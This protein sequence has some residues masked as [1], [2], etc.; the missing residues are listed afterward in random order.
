MSENED[1]EPAPV[2]QDEPEV[3]ESE[4]PKAKEPEK[5]AAKPDKKDDKDDEDSV[6]PTGNRPHWARGL[7]VFA[8]GAAIP[9][10][11]MC[12]DQHWPFSVP[13]GL[14]GC[15][16]AAWGLFDAFGTFDDSTVTRR[17]DIAKLRPAA[18][19]LGTAIAAWF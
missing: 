15:L 4:P 1:K 12:T 14:L 13:V 19:E 11:I 18:L 2:S 17:A 16:I 5:N 6:V 8:V 3:S 10:I 9:F 7:S